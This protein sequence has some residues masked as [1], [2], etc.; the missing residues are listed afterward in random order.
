MTL[1][2]V[3]AVPSVKGADVCVGSVRPASGGVDG[4]RDRSGRWHR[5]WGKGWRFGRAVGRTSGG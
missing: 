3:G 4:W 2:M 5:G 1:G